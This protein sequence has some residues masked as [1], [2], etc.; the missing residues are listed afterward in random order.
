MTGTVGYDA[1]KKQ[2]RIEAPPHVLLRL[3]RVFPKISR[4]HMGTLFLSDTEETA[5]DLEWFLERYPMEVSDRA[6]LVELAAAYRDREAIVDSMLA[7]K[8]EAPEFELEIPARE[9]QRLAAGL[10][11]A[12]GGLLLADDVGLGKTCSAICMLVDKRT[13]PAVV[14]T[15]THLTKQWQR[16]IARFAPKLRSHIVKQGTPYDLTEQPKRRGKAG[17]QI[18]LPGALPDVI[19]IN[20]HKLSGWAET[21]API[22]QD[23]ALVLDE[24][25]ELRNTDSKRYA[26]AMHLARHAAF[27]MSMSAT[28]IYNYGDEFFAVLDV[29]RPGVGGT[30]S[31]FLQEW[32][33]EGQTKVIAEPNAFGSYLR[34]S[35]LMLRR[36]RA[37]V[38]RELPPITKVI[39]H[40]ESD[41][42]ALDDASA[43][44]AEL[45]KILLRQSE[46]ARGEKMNAAAEFDVR[47]RQAT[48]I[49]K[50]PFVAEFVRMLVDSGESV[51]L[52]GWHRAVYE[53]WLDRL[54]DLAPAM[55]TGTESAAQ[56]DEAARRFTSGQTKV[57]IMSLRA[58]AGL[59]GLQHACRTVVTGELDWSPA[60]L[61]QNIGRVA[62]DQQK[63]PVTAYFLVADEGADPIMVDV[64]GLK[65]AQLD[66]VRDVNAELVEK[67]EIDG[68]RIKR[69][70][71]SYLRQRGITAMNGEVAA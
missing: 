15:M 49:A 30:R 60:I 40:V 34:T 56:K 20:Y 51:V 71:E 13:T 27:R 24:V 12:S 9:Y 37:D 19:I 68:D 50:A 39:H 43:A 5:R 52:F 7:R 58:G 16:E 11:L 3:K 6:R 46:T 61:E 32:C 35:G 21:L 29:T 64:L 33:K 2:W 47:L 31:E 53:I 18:A 66:G 14:V 41:A 25:A 1:K 10:A 63:D 8:V 23:H 70:A 69:L 48:G 55:Y 67:L 4:R 44:C 65:R 22:V 36:T 26:A 57:L 17:D 38:A 42:R 62:R 59:D 45:A 54:K 28:P